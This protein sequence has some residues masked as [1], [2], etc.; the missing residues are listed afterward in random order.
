M[1]DLLAKYPASILS[2]L[3]DAASAYSR[4]Q[5][6]GTVMKVCEADG[7]KLDMPDHSQLFKM[8]RDDSARHNRSH[9]L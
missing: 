6:E 4:S 8:G 9:K 3:W 1:H 7:R 5:F 2:H